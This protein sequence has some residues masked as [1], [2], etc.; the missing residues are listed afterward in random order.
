MLFEKTMTLLHEKVNQE[1]LSDKEKFLKWSKYW[2]DYFIKCIKEEDFKVITGIMTYINPI[3][4]KIN[5]ASSG[6]LIDI[7]KRICLLA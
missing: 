1:K 2:I 4:C 3:V 5:R 7:V 6:F